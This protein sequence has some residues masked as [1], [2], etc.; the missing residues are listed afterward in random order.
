ML[1][2]DERWYNYCVQNSFRFTGECNNP[3]AYIK[4]CQ[5][6]GSQFLITNQ[7]F[8]ITYKRCEGIGETFDAGQQ[9]L[10]LGALT[11]IYRESGAWQ[12]FSIIVVEYSC[13]GDWFV[14]KNHFFAVANTKESRI[15]EKYRCFLKNR[16]DDLYIGVS[17]TPHCNTLKTVEDSPE[18][19]RITPGMHCDCEFHFL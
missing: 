9:T 15:E 1:G 14:D 12:I 11:W 19:L 13:L 4:S 16:D 10:F 3:E 17:I 6:A 18:R 5:T 7:K 8:N 2:P